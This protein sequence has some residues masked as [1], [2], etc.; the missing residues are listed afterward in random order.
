M[1]R[2][3]KR[4]RKAVLA[5]PGLRVGA[6][7]LRNYVLHQ[8]ANQA[9]SVAFPWLLSMFPT[10]LLLSAAAVF[11]GRPGDALHPRSSAT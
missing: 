7:A 10:A 8:S 5:V 9:G 3:W 11:V 2:R 6:L 4:V 1:D